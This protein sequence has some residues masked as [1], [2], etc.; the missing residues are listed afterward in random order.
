MTV[1][2]ILI[3]V[4]IPLSVLCLIALLYYLLGNVYKGLVT[5]KNKVDSSW[6]ELRKGYVKTLNLIPSLIQNVTMTQEEKENF[7]FVYKS[8][9]KMDLDKIGTD[10]FV[11]LIVAYLNEFNNISEKNSENDTVKFIKEA[12]RN[13]KFSIPFYNY[14]VDIYRKFRNLPINILMAHMFNFMEVDNFV[15]KDYSQ[16]NTTLDLRVDNF[17]Y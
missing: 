9:K 3:V 6:N 7:T 16:G 2:Q 12:F 10:D 11:S 15:L 14:N 1:E 4:L 17:K 5:R 8:Y 13:A